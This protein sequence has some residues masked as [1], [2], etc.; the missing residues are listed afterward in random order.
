MTTLKGATLATFGLAL[1]AGVLLGN[2]GDDDNTK[3]CMDACNK[4]KSCS[5]GLP[6]TVD[7]SQSCKQPS[8]MNNPESCPN[9]AAI[10]PKFKEC[11]SK[12]CETYF[13]CL[14]A[15]PPCEGGGGTGGTGGSSGAGGAGGTSGSG[16]SAGRGGGGGSS[17]A[18]GSSS[19]GAGGSGTGGT[20][21]TG[22]CADCAKA[23]QCAT[24]LVDGGAAGDLV[25][26]CN[27]ATGATKT[28]LSM[29]CTLLATSPLCQ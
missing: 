16:G 7:C 13:D 21:G 25:A 17:G 15:L 19:G 1:A 24:R 26:Q 28:Q 4:F 6:A 23:Q 12:P 5:E 20:G 18:G 9:S 22:S 8:T 14:A 29:A 3:L 11:L 27:A 2:C 10:I